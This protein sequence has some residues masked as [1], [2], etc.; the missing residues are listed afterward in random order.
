L[1]ELPKRLTELTEE[2][3]RQILE[4]IRWKGIPTCPYCESQKSRKLKN[5]PRY[6]CNECFTS[7]SVTVG[8]IFHKTRVSLK[9]SLSVIYL[10]M[11]PAPRLSIRQIAEKL[12]LNKNTVSLLKKK[13]ATDKS[14]FLQK[15]SEK[16]K[17]LKTSGE[18]SSV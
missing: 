12:S 17:S 15:I 13:V 18:D 14:N 8:T 3:C 10:L 16:I 9:A 6:Q 2:E 7:Y 5:E 4:E 11:Q 1:D